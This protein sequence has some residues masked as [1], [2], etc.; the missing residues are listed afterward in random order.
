MYKRIVSRHF[1]T[2]KDYEKFV[3]LECSSYL[4]HKNDI[5]KLKI[6]F[7]F[8]HKK[9]HNIIIEQNKDINILQDEI[10]NLSNELNEQKKLLSDYKK[11]LDKYRETTLKFWF[12]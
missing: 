2:T 10:V 4:S 5:D 6:K 3:N 8:I 12:G 1:L 9:F 7:N 11:E